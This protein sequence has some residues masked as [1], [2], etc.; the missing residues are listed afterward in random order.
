[1]N[2]TEKARQQ[3]RLWIDAGK[4]LA[5]DPTA[6]VVCPSCGLGTLDVHDQVVWK[7]ER[8]ERW[9]RCDYCSV[10]NSL[11]MTPS[12]AG[13]HPSSSAGSLHEKNDDQSGASQSVD[14]C[15]QKAIDRLVVEA[16]KLNKEK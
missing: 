12:D 9:M 8:V 10:A 13:I 15:D 5:Q 3:M 11:L 2:R 16:V 1:M 4:T 7:G 14:W 6:R